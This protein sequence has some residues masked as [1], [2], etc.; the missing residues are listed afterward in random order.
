VEAALMATLAGCV[1]PAP[2][3]AWA[4]LLARADDALAFQT[5]RWIDCLCAT[6]RY[7]DATRLYE[8]RDGRRLLVPMV[9]RAGLAW[10]LGLQAS[11][12]YGWGFGGI[13]ASDPPSAADVSGVL[14]D[15]LGAGAARVSLRPNP[16]SAEVWAR[17]A[18]PMVR[19]VPR[20]A[21][22]VD[23]EG[24]F[25]QVQAR[26]RSGARRAIRKAERS[27]LTVT[28]DTSG[29]HVPV[30]HSLYQRSVDRW[31]ANKGEPL[32]LARRRAALREPEAKFR[33]VADHLGP[34]CQIWTAWVDARPAASIVVLRHGRSASYWR[35]AMDTEVAPGAQPNYL[36]HARAIE[37]ACRAGC[38]HYHMG[39]TGS[40]KSLAQFKSRFGARPYEYFEYRI[41]RLPLTEMSERIGSWIA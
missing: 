18:P 4:E 9:R 32:W 33:R 24:G 23:L 31:A 21:H 14:Q 34:A 20:V 8:T 30:F 17:G 11:L 28:C 40:S 16:L 36:L 38:R 15:L 25:D 27:A 6:G 22:V 2:R 12:P 41:E 1:S 29:A 3:E 35:G 37:E 10:P 26:F 19:R 5:P 7:R 13:L 39:E